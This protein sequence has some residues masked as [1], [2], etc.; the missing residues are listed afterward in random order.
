MHAWFI[1]ICTVS[2]RSQIPTVLSRRGCST[3][4]YLVNSIRESNTSNKEPR[5]HSRVGRPTRSL[6]YMVAMQSEEHSHNTA[7][8]VVIRGEQRIIPRLLTAPERISASSVTNKRPRQS[9][10]S[11]EARV[12][13]A[14]P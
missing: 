8:P 6:N 2:S 10:F 4:L 3:F 14:S 13:V 11:S 12:I 7:R 5:C 1:S 9:R